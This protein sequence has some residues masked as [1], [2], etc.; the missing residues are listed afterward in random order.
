MTPAEIKQYIWLLSYA[1]KI[2]LIQ[3]IAD[4]LKEAVDDA[5]FSGLDEA[6]KRV[7][8]KGRGSWRRS[9]MSTLKPARWS[10][11]AG[12]SA[13]S[14]PWV[15]VRST[16]NFAATRTLPIPPGVDHDARRGTASPKR[17]GGFD[18]DKTASRRGFLKRSAL[19]GTGTGSAGGHPP[20]RNRRKT[21]QRGRPRRSGRHV[22]CPSAVSRD[23]GSPRCRRRTGGAGSRR[24]ACPPSRPP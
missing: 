8:P 19:A 13:S 2:Q 23:R 17:S 3:D 7:G 16:L 18:M 11:T 21:R 12:M 14:T 6:A 15:L 1:E 5:S 9:N 10:S 4:M 20:P 24:T 22:T